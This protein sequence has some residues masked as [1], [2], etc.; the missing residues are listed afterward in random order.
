MIEIKGIDLKKIHMI[1]IEIEYKKISDKNKQMLLDNL[2]IE[3]IWKS[4]NKLVIEG[5]KVW[6]VLTAVDIISNN[7]W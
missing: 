6:D 1:K 3:R 4:K 7:K 2:H 5:G